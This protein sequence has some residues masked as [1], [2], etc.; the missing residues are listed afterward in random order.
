MAKFDELDMQQKSILRDK[1]TQ[2]VHKYARPVL[3]GEVAREIKE[4]LDLTEEVLNE[5][6]FGLFGEAP[7]LKKLFP[8]DPRRKTYG[9]EVDLYE[10]S[11]A[12][13]LK[14]AHSAH[15]VAE[16]SKKR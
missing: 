13:S 4:S 15:E 7:V 1:I 12:L 5:M 2:V 9:S 14:I 11:G 10:V 8:S 16:R 3:I 6:C